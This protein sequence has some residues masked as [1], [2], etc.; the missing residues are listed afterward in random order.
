MSA[1]RLKVLMIGNSFSESV[2]TYLPSMVK[3]DG[4]ERLRL[5]QAYIGGC[6]IE[7]HLNEY[8]A[9]I[10]DPEYRPYLTNIA[11][12][13]APKA[14]KGRWWANVPEMLR[15]DKWDIV[16]IQQGSSQCWIPESYAGDAARL[17][18]IVRKLAPQAEIVLHKTWSYRSDAPLLAEWGFDNS[19]MYRRLSGAYAGV[20]AE[21]GFRIIPVGD[22]V[23]IFRSRQKQPYIPLTEEEKSRLRW[24]DMPSA[25]ADLVGND[26]WR[27]NPES[28]RMELG[29]DHIHLNPRG[30]YLQ[31]CVWYMFLFGK[32]AA[33]I[34]F[35]PE[36]FDRQFCIEMRDIAE[37]ALKA[38][39]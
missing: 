18:G 20:S 8:D 36:N 33:D 13:G 15:E 26:R 30:C 29:A 24:P 12:K 22:A 39:R 37:E 10:A 32:H 27:K 19:E 38:Y 35:E 14:H 34:S 3:A 9:A 2:L 11:L 21:Y 5:R 28:G 16:T 31:A 23:N 25:S 17:I 1:K 6:T 4:K 7:R